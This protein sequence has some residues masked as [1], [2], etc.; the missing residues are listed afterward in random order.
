MADNLPV[1]FTITD[2]AQLHI[3][4]WMSRKASEGAVFRIGIKGGGC[5][6]YEYFF[7]IDANA[8]PNDCHFS[9]G[10]YDVVCDPKSDKLLNGA[11]LE[12]SGNLLGGGLTFDN[13]NA[14]RS[15]GC[16]HSFSLKKIS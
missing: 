9:V 15:C 7:R 11:T 13:P 14:D 12:Y 10:D 6:G 8:K 1:S 16:G 2:E 5:S 3:Q 4:K